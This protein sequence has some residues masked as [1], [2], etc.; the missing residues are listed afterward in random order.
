[1]Q[2]QLHKFIN[3]FA[4]VLI[5]FSAGVSA[6][7]VED[8]GAD[9]TAAEEAAEEAGP[10]NA[11][12]ALK[13][14]IAEAK[15]DGRI[16][17]EQ[18]TWRTQ[19]PKFP[20]VAFEAG[21]TYVWTLETS[22]GVMEA[23]LMPEVA[24]DHVRNILYLSQLGFYDGL[25]FHRIIPGFMA[26]GGCPLGRGTGGPGYSLPLEVN[27]DALHD[28]AGTL[29]MARS[30]RPDSAGSQFFI[31]FGVTRNLDMQYSVF[32][33]VTE[34]LDVVRKLEAAGNPN[35]RSNGVPPLKEIHI[36]R[37]T[38]AWRAGEAA[39]SE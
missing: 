22:E 8:E 7:T 29:S 2:S 23:E 14:F 30:A 16:D 4:C 33:R 13:G 32:G 21:G 36:E 28:V 27:R 3:S 37:A 19:L 11:L 1:M 25:K 17:L 31:T 38:V 26:Q 6:E 35:P 12:E 20:A 24:P 5:L 15:E 18:D 10:A 34:G 39:E 9:V